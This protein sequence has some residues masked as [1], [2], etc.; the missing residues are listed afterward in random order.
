MRRTGHPRVKRVRHPPHR[1]PPRLS[2]P[3]EH[4]SVLL[5]LHRQLLEHLQLGI[6][7]IKPKQRILITS[8]CPRLQLVEVATERRRPVDDHTPYT[9][10]QWYY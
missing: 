6:E 2:Y 1:V 4:R 10:R 7:P 5:R 9:T 8:A 3:L